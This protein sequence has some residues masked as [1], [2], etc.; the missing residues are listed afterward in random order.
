MFVFFFGF[1]RSSQPPLTVESI[2]AAGG[3]RETGA[4]HH[5]PSIS[6]HITSDHSAGGDM[7]K[8]GAVWLKGVCLQLRGQSTGAMK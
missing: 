3:E 4:F 2:P 1:L 8:V 5:R 7:R 6:R